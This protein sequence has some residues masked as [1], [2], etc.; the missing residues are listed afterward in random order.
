V[1]SAQKRLANGIGQFLRRHQS[2]MRRR[3]RSG[4]WNL[5]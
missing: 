4:Y 5:C 1:T 3:M 2:I